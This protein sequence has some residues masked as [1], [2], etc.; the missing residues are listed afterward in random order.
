MGHRNFTPTLP[1]VPQHPCQ[2]RR[3]LTGTLPRAPRLLR[4]NV[5]YEEGESPANALTKPPTAPQPSLRGPRSRRRFPPF[6]HPATA[7]PSVSRSV[8]TPTHTHSV[9][10]VPSPLPSRLPRFRGTW[11]PPRPGCLLPRRVAQRERLR[12]LGGSPGNFPHPPQRSQGEKTVRSETGK[13]KRGG[14]GG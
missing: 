10:S 3:P 1:S 8:P 11:R 4:A 6:S 5:R 2:G 14:G 12:A 9:G 7:I 13:R